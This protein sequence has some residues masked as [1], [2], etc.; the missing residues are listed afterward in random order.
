MVISAPVINTNCSKWINSMI[1]INYHKKK[2]AAK[3]ELLRKN[4]RRKEIEQRECSKSDNWKY[5]Y[6]KACFEELKDRVPYDIYK[7]I[8]KEYRTN[9]HLEKIDKIHQEEIE[10][11]NSKNEKIDSL[12][13]KIQETQSNWKFFIYRFIAFLFVIPIPYLMY[14]YGGSV[15]FGLSIFIMFIASGILFNNEKEEILKKLNTELDDE[16]NFTLTK[17]FLEVEPRD[18]F[19]YEKLKREK[20]DDSF[21][22]EATTV[23]YLFIE[24]Y[25]GKAYKIG[26]TNQ[27]ISERF[28]EDFCKITVLDT[29][30]CKTRIEAYSIEQEILRKYK[31]FQYKGKDLLS[32]GNTE[33]FYLDIRTEI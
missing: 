5:N 10:R 17:G 2:E 26:I 18:Y 33:L 29:M 8:Q 13:K 16:I 30:L 21:F 11:F 32:N 4:K 15:L 1:D 24:D 28:G 20:K 31:K 12:N 19:S 27:K 6:Y 23:Y 25:D 7:K 3:Q 22:S 14:L 9:E